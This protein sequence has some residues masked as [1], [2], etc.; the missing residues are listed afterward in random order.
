MKVNF[1]STM[2]PI[3]SLPRKQAHVVSIPKRRHEAARNKRSKFQIIELST[4]K[5]K[6]ISGAFRF[7]GTT[8]GEGAVSKNST[9]CLSSGQM[10]KAP[11][12]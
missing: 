1:V 9:A 3:Q 6:A 5:R 7:D 12:T 4:G 2:G 11:R 8:G 10:E